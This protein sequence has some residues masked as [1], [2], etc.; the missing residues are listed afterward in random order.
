MLIKTGEASVGEMFLPLV[1]VSKGYSVSETFVTC[2]N[3]RV[4]SDWEVEGPGRAWRRC[5]AQSGPDVFS[6]KL[7]EGA[8]ATKRFDPCQRQDR[9]GIQA[10]AA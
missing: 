3:G 9:V 7:S 2:G 10:V 1:R 8:E 5:V 6:L 4:P